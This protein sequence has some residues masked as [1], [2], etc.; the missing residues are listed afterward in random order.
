MQV[1]PALPR[2][3]CTRGLRGVA[4]AAS[5]IG[6][7]EAEAV[8]LTRKDLL[9]TLLTAFCVFVF[10]ATHEGWRVWLVGSSHHWAAG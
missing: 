6:R 8:A 4:P 1:F 3:Q 2:R 10:F 9:A 7:E 5:R